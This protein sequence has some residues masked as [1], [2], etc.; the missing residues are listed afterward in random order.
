[1]G[2]LLQGLFGERSLTK[3][4]GIFPSRAAAE[5]AA[6]GLSAA[7]ALTADQVRTLGPEDASGSRNTLLGRSIEPEQGGIFRTMVRAH[8]VLGA[9]GAAA[10][11]AVYAALRGAGQPAI[12]SSPGFSFGTIVGLG[13]IFG[14]LLGG[15]IALRPDHI[16]LINEVRTA[17]KSGGWAVVAHPTRA[18]QTDAAAAYFT[19]C[20][21]R[22]LRSL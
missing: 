9:L 13:T 3:V 5:A 8:V 6:A 21:A 11:V 15:L 7:A 22:V 2:Y 12:L 14:L 18:Q 1:M 16:K 10:G 20:G 19:K 17:L 4:V